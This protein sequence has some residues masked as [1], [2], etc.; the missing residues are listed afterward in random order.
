MR[1][2]RGLARARRGRSARRASRAPSAPSTRA[3]FSSTATARAASA[4]VG[5]QEHQ[6]G[7]VRAGRRQREVDH[8]AEE[9]VRHLDHDAGAVAGVGLG[10]AGTPVV[11]PAQRRAAARDHVMGAPARDIDHERHAARV[12]LVAGVVEALRW[13]DVM[14]PPASSMGS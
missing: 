6:A 7:G 5:R 11:Q 13:V 10:A 8:G 12:V 9:L 1:R 2:Q 14:T 3:Y 4:V